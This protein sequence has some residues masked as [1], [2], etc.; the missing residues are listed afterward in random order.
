MKAVVLS[1]GGSKG[2]YQ[3][4]V[5]KALRKLHIKYDIV[6]GTSVGA[7]NGALMVQNSFKKACKLWK[8]IDMKLLFCDAATESRKK[9]DILNMYRV[10]FFKHGGMDVEN[11]QNLIKSLIKQDV[12]YQ[13]RINYGLVTVNLSGKKAMQLEKKNIPK[14][15]LADYL[16]ASASCYPAF[17]KKDIDGKKYIDGG[18]FDNLPINFA[19]SLGADDIIAVDLC[20][21]GFKQRIKNKKNL[22]IVT[23]KPNNK[24]S[25]FLDFNKEGAKKNIRYGYNDT[26]KIYGK[27]FG[28]KYTFK[29]RNFSS[30]IDEYQDIF[31]YNFKKVMNTKKL[32][33]LFKLEE[34]D[35]GN[36]ILKIGEGMGYLFNFDDTKIY[37][38]KTFNRR[39][40]K[41]VNQYKKNKSISNKRIE[42]VIKLY[43]KMRKKDYK[44]LR[45]NGMIN[46]KDFI[47]ALY[48]Y[49]LSE[50]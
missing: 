18:L 10:N 16:M 32:S 36:F 41:Q 17:Q 48:L 38:F 22:H 28:Y 39:L 9:V 23:I 43:D 6:T 29:K 49:T 3:I 50:V 19:A 21:P 15:K 35:I 33:T 25:N 46:P 11:L 30:L 42:N 5:W 8:K 24:L 2:S 1:G 13:S 44:Y 20:A 4:G 34:K 37:N 7:L 47:Y 31:L 40:L 45:V 14:D 12:F 26:M 27:Y